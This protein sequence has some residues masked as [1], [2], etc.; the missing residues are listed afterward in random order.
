MK[1]LLALLMFLSCFTIHAQRV[2]LTMTTAKKIGEFVSFEVGGGSKDATIG[3]FFGETGNSFTKG[4]DGLIHVRGKIEGPTIQIFCDKSICDFYL[5]CNELTSVNVRNHNGIKSLFC[6]S[7]RLTTLDV[8]INTELTHLSCSSNKL[9]SLNISNNAKL[10]NLHCGNNPLINLDVSNNKELKYLYC[11]KNQLTSLNVANNKKLKYLHCN[12]NE[13]KFSTLPLLDIERYNYSPQQRLNIYESILVNKP[14]NLRSEYIIGGKT[15]T[16]VWK[17][18]TGRLLTEGVDYSMENGITTF[19]KESSEPVYCE[20]KNDYFNGLTIKTTPINVFVTTEKDDLIT[21]TTSKKVGDVIDFVASGSGSGETM[22]V[23]FGDRKPIAYTPDSHNVFRIVGRLRGQMIKIYGDKSINSFNLNSNQL[24]SIDF[25]KHNELIT[26]RCDS[27]QLTSLDVSKNKALVTLSCTHNKLKISTLPIANIKNFICHPQQTINIVEDIELNIPLDLRTEYKIDGKTTTYIWKTKTGKILTKGVDYSIKNGLTTFLKTQY[28][29]VYCEMTNELFKGLTINTTLVHVPKKHNL[30]IAMTTSG[31]VGWSEIYIKTGKVSKYGPLHVD[32]GDGNLISFKPNFH[33]G[34]FDIKGKV[35]GKN[36][37]IYGDETVSS[38]YLKYNNLTSIDVSKHAAL[39][40]LDCSN[41]QLTTLDVSKNIALT[42]LDCSNNQ[43]TTLDVSKHNALTKLNCSSNKLT[44]L[45]V[46]KNATLKKIDCYSNQLTTL[47]V[48]RN[49]KLEYLICGKNPLTQ[50][51]LSKNTVLTKLACN[52]NQLTELD[53][54]KNTALTELNCRKNQLLTL[55][56]SKNTVLTELYCYSNYLTSLNISNNNALTRLDCGGNKLTTLNISENRELDYVKCSYNQ[57]STIDVSNN[58]A[59]KELNCAYN[60]ITL[61]NLGNIGALNDL[62]C[63]NNKLKFSTLPIHKFKYYRFE[64]QQ[65]LS[66]P[67]NITINMP[68]DLKSEYIVKGNATTYTWK[69][70]TGNILEKGVDYSI[71]SGITTFLK[72]QADPVYCEMTNSS[73]NRLKI[74]TTPVNVYVPSAK[75]HLISM[76]TRKEEGEIIAF[77]AIG[78]RFGVALFVDFGDGNLMTYVPDYHGIF[79]IKGIIKGQTINIYGDKSINEFRLNKNSLTMLDVS[80]HTTLKTLYCAD[81]YYLE[82]L[83]LSTNKALRTL[84]CQYNKLTSLDVSNTALEKLDCNTNRLNSLN[85]SN[86]TLKELNCHSNKL[87]SLDVSNNLALRTLV[88]HYNKLASL[89]VSNNL[90]LR[91]LDCGLNKLTRLDLSTNKALRTLDCHYN[92]LTSLD[93]SNNLVL[94]TLDCS[95]NNLTSL[96]VSNAALKELDCSGNYQLTTL[97]V[98][99][100]ISLIELGCHSNKLTSLD[101]SNNISLVELDCSFNRLSNLDVSKNTALTKLNCDRNQLTSLDVKNSGTIKSIKVINNKLKFSTLPILNVENYL[102]VPQ[103]NILIDRYIETGG[104]IDLGSEFMVNGNM[105]IY[106]WKTSSGNILVNGVDYL[107]EKGITTFTK[108][109]TEPLYCE[110]K[111]DSF[112]GLTIKTTLVHFPAK[113]EL[114]ITLTTTKNIDEEMAFSVGLMDSVMVDF[115]NGNLL[116]FKKKSTERDI[117]IKGM[118]KG[119]TIKIYGD[120]TKKNDFYIPKFCKITELDVSNNTKLTGL[121]CNSNQ[122]TKL[123][124]SKNT[125]L[126]TLECSNN[127]LKFSTLPILNINMYEYSSQQNLSIVGNIEINTPLDL[128]SEY[129]INGRITTYTWKAITGRILE[130]GIDY[131]IKNG[132]TT[133]LR[134]QGEP[135]YCEMKNSQ[136]SR[137]TLKTTNVILEQSIL[138]EFTTAKNI[139]EEIN[140]TL[141]YIS[142]FWV[143][144]GDGNLMKFER[145]GESIFIDVKGYL[146]GQTIKIY[147]DKTQGNDLTIPELSKIT[148]I[149]VSSNSNLLGLICS[150]NLLTD[151]DVSNN[152]MLLYLYCNSN[153]LTSLDVSNNTMLEYL[154]CNSNNLTS[155]DVGSKRLV[156]LECEHNRLKLST[157][158]ILYNSLRLHSY[159]PQEDLSIVENIEI[160]TPLDLSSEYMIDGNAT[161]YAWKTTSG[162]ILTEGVDYFFENGFTTFTSAQAEPV[163]CEM[164]NDLFSKLTLKTTAVNISIPTTIDYS[165]ENELKVYSSDKTVYIKTS[166]NPIV[167]I[168]DISG[169]VITQKQCYSGVTQINVPQSGIYLVT[170]IVDNKVYTQ[171]VVIR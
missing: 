82:V 167:C 52:N 95:F 19:L 103:Q 49:T 106:T 35:K 43:L 152:T 83:D 10:E 135:V 150:N 129:N 11:N 105:T 54:S 159:A 155:L 131:S 107:I 32:F 153:N 44:T 45:N 15:T 85:I 139:G 168:R 77:S 2:L 56:V 166:L 154:D 53:V 110:M 144:F 142:S 127:K 3:V 111:N 24:T 81:N 46:S 141:A 48:R 102:Y 51:D 18:T 90:A 47:D 41:N 23:D 132:V 162:T 104:S 91:T 6:G 86:T 21:M 84:D 13:L 100:N 134:A 25:S 55:D 108:V 20:M 133:F 14:L 8:S 119:H 5:C 163:Y 69:T 78:K 137:L 76:S 171:K 40:K 109:Q 156:K 158:P 79:N 121:S 50:L 124:V 98:S 17:T 117:Y 65:W 165:F 80:N 94:S 42:E 34:I 140:F 70:T 60:Q 161:T 89:D 101:V 74:E 38:F 118:I 112:K 93:V 62:N 116:K 16:Y 125:S 147:G 92:K 99:N 115:G 28:M 113:Q 145:D 37:K 1:N 33:Q 39:T 22:L 148:E 30:L 97:D 146:K 120:K 71:D 96:D 27:N 67:V 26:I 88:C 4:P 75:D 73:F 123:D 66:I 157:L 72:P 128:S 9:T 126:S 164:K 130:K 63:K 160:N 136:F 61:M 64:P 114:L 151:L 59:L 58:I 122:L 7:N 36:I 31:L 87:T 169:K 149:D 57:L 12:D 68:L 143:D 138:Y 170:L 29:P